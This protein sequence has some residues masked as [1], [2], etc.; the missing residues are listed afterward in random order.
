MTGGGGGGGGNNSSSPRRFTSTLHHMPHSGGG[1][2]SPKKEATSSSCS[3]GGG[4]GGGGGPNVRHI[5]IMVEGRDELLLPSV[6]EED[7]ANNK[8]AK[9]KAIPMPFYPQKTEK[10]QA[11]AE[12]EVEAKATVH[13]SSIP[14]PL[15]YDRLSDDSSTRGSA[16]DQAD[17]RLRADLDQIERIRR[18][19]ETLMPRIEAFN[20]RDRRDRDFVYLDEMLTRLLLKLD[21]VEVE[22]R[23]DVR[24]ARKGAITSIQR[25]INLLE[26]KILSGIQQSA[27]DTDTV[28]PTPIDPATIDPPLPPPIDADASPVDTPPV[29][30]VPVNSAE[31][32]PVAA[33][34]GETQ[35]D[36][37]VVVVGQAEADLEPNTKQ[38][39]ISQLVVEIP[40]KDPNPPPPGGE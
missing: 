18:E 5:P 12:A 19:T 8:D 1:N 3:G 7:G 10:P 21:N 24:L 28:D 13:N 20:G 16:P 33:D 17:G 35:I 27:D 30:A 40:F 31:V 4:S 38:Q 39:H 36:D 23:D 37:N 32:D 34:G 2:G 25:C 29:D 22:G 11:R 14:I 6:V 26:S 9:K 15:P